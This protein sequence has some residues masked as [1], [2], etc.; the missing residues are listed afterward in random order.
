M[1]VK[2]SHDSQVDIKIS[3]FGCSR[4]MVLDPQ[5]S[6]PT[7]AGT[8]QYMVPEVRNESVTQLDKADVYSFAVMCSAILTGEEP[9]EKVFPRRDLQT[10]I[11]KGVRPLL[12]GDLPEEFSKLIRKRWDT[13]PDA[14]PDFKI[15]CEVLDRSRRFWA[16]VS[17]SH[18]Q[19]LDRH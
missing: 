1:M 7:R 19:I 14:R 5:S 16:Q 13:N 4:L 11:L 9:F 18:S 15:I 17:P 6:E 2:L 8:T 12:P 3:D 10:H